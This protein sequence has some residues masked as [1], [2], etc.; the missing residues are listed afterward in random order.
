MHII[1]TYLSLIIL[2]S[3]SLGSLAQRSKDSAVQ[4]TRGS[5]SIDGQL[6]EWGE[7]AH[8]YVTQGFKYDLRNDADF[9]YLGVLIE[10][11]AIQTQVLLN[12]FT[13]SINTKAKKKDGVSVIYPL[14]DR[15]SLRSLRSA[16]AKED[17]R[18]DLIAA[19]RGIYVYR[20]NDLVDGLISL[21]NTYGVSAKATINSEDHLVL[22]YAIPLRRLGLGKSHD[23]QIAVNLKIN[24]AGAPITSTNNNSTRMANP[25]MGSR[26][27]GG[28]AVRQRV[29]NGVWF[30]TTLAK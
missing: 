21:D 3:I 23:G 18:L 26:V 11:R 4:V 14:V 10:D 16:E 30:I 9:I 6:D 1:R 17:A 12:G 29:E 22:E 15:V 20:F 28:T 7:L 25:T 19:V 24:G 27:Y 8:Q 13:W 5:A 2:L